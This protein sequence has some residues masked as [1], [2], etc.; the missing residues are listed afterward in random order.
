MKKPRPH[1]LPMTL[2]SSRHPVRFT[3]VAGSEYMVDLRSLLEAACLSWSRWSDTVR[4]LGRHFKWPL[5]PSIDWKGQATLLVSAPHMPA[6]LR[7]LEAALAA[8]YPPG[9]KRVRALGA[10]WSREWAR[11]ARLERSQG[12]DGDADE[13]VGLEQGLAPPAASEKV[14]RQD[15]GKDFITPEVAERVRALAASGVSYRNI[16]RRLGIGAGTA[17]MLARGV[18]KLSTRADGGRDGG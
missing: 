11:V 17:N 8:I 10:S 15:R 5:K 18:Y 4:L 14:S 16:G 9:A 2:S 1:Y 7:S 13:S 3:T 6:V 12:A